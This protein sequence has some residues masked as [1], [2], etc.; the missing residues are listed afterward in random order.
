MATAATDDAR[1]QPRPGRLPLAIAVAVVAALAVSYYLYVRNQRAYFSS[2]NLRL[3]E[4]VSDQLDEA[5]RTNEGFVRNY[6]RSRGTPETFSASNNSKNPVGYLPGFEW[7]ARSCV[8]TTAP[9]LPPIFSRALAWN[10]NVPVFTI[11]Y[12]ETVAPLVPVDAPN[13]QKRAVQLE[14]CE[15]ALRALRQAQGRIPLRAVLEPIFSQPLLSVFDDVMLVRGDGKVIFTGHQHTSGTATRAGE[16]QSGPE[17]IVAN[18]GRL[19]ERKGWRQ[20]DR[21]DVAAL[22]EVTRI[23]EVQ[24]SGGTHYLF[25]QP[26]AHD[27]VDSDT[28]LEKPEAAKWIVAGV[29]SKRRF[30]YEVLSVTASGVLAVLALLVMM[31]CAWPYLRTTLIGAHQRLT[32]ADVL[33][34]GTAA[35]IHASILTLLVV[36]VLAY[37]SLRA[38]TDRQLMMFGDRLEQALVDDLTTAA[39]TL[40][41]LDV[42]AMDEGAA[43]RWAQSD[44]LSRVAADPSIVALSLENPYV[45]SV[46]WID[47]EGRQ[48]YKASM[49]DPTPLVNV[50]HRSYFRDANMKRLQ[51]LDA[52]LDKQHSVAIDS[53]R[54]STT[55]ETE[56][57]VAQPSGAEGLPVVAATVQL[58]RL[59]Y[60]VM[61]PGFGFAIIDDSG[62]VLFHSEESRNNQENFFTETDWNRTVRSAVYARH[63]RLTSVNYWGEDHRV[64]VRPLELPWTLIVFRN[65]SLLRTVNTEAVAMTLS[66][67]IGNALIYVMVLF[68]VLLWRP[69]YRAPHMWPVAKNRGLY[70]QLI[71]L[72][73]I[74]IASASLVFYAFDALTALQI[75]MLVPAQALAG[76]LLILEHRRDLLRWRASRVVW[77]IV[78]LIWAACLLLSE[79]MPGTAVASL[80]IV[81]VAVGL[82]MLVLTWWATFRPADYENVPLSY[83]RAYI[84]AGVLL[85]VI[86]AVIPTFGFFKVA[87]RLEIEGWVKY[88]QLA[89]AESAEKA[90]IETEKLN[91]SDQSSQSYCGEWTDDPFATQWELVPPSTPGC[92]KLTAATDLT[93]VPV[94]HD[95]DWLPDVYRD[96]LPAYS[97]ESVSLRQ[98]HGASTGEGPWQWLWQNDRITLSKDIRLPVLGESGPAAAAK[99]YSDL[100]PKQLIKVHM[101]VPLSFAA[102]WYASRGWTSRRAIW[103][104]VFILAVIAVIAI[105]ILIVRFFAAK[106]FLI[107]LHEPLWLTRRPLKPTLGDHVFLIGQRVEQV[108]EEASEFIDVKFKELH[109]SKDANAWDD[110]LLQIDR[111][112]EG[113][114]VRIFDFDHDAANAGLSMKKLMFLERLLALPNRTVIVASAVTPAAFL[115]LITNADLKKRWTAVLDSFVWVTESQLQPVPADEDPHEPRDTAEWL[116]RETSWGGFLERLRGELSPDSEREQLKDEILERASTYYAGL[117]SSCSAAE[118]ILLHQLAREGLVNGKDRKS[119][120][121]LLARGFVRRRPNLRLFNDTFRLYVLAAAK[122]EHVPVD[123]QEGPSAWD[124]IR[125]PLFVVFISVVI[126]ILATQKDMLNLATG[127]VA[128]L[129]TGVPAIVR[130]FGFLTERRLSQ[131]EKT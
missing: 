79:T 86:G 92:G 42:W 85:L 36:D 37:R 35:L 68:L 89:I 52:R 80:W 38:V 25:T 102:A 28:S 65:K 40:R 11:G 69:R 72:Y 17:H 90:I 63:R 101:R 112:D 50:A 15:E 44:V 2:R 76:T 24:S 14:P 23:A 117:W 120:R 97:E 4:T 58:V 113:K 8:P 94:K 124:T 41:K 27:T 82:G 131:T 105:L 121:R 10:R 3:L 62:Q 118:K 122:R 60:A 61:P 123:T 99:I 48:R 127:L 70:L 45:S 81:V 93:G 67:L 84:A 87:S 31:I 19:D 78:T 7:A 104:V 18:L 116:R 106:L 5:L 111:A 12:Q 59:K 16:G 49:R 32:I 74:T 96:V 100:P 71:V 39:K 110:K 128:A 115:A 33:L 73:A 114:N 77:L 91:T 46:A 88:S 51:Q 109:E 26:F 129:T 1:A 6:G 98:L 21:L 130:L 34:L 30:M 75:T 125:V 107:D 66:M 57:I 55:G 103:F 29:V 54:S 108:T 13:K 64:F 83:S 9:E 22:R 56:V 43:Q 47:P 20:T 95:R 126:M 119:V 53:I